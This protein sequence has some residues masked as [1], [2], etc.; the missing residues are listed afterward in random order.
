METF[1]PDT[2][3]AAQVI[4]VVPEQR[5]AQNKNQSKTHE[6]KLKKKNSTKIE[7]RKKVEWNATRYLE[8]PACV[9]QLAKRFGKKLQFFE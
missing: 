3:V 4:V 6:E 5:S 8:M 1:L 9:E 2:Q 7:K